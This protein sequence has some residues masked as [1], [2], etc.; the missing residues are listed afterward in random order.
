MEQL[1]WFPVTSVFP[2]PSFRVHTTAFKVNIEIHFESSQTID[3]AAG[4]LNEVT[5][6]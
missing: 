4:Y 3:F 1:C 6:G 2:F 5:L